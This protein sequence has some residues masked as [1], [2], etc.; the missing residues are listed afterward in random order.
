MLGLKGRVFGHADALAVEQQLGVAQ[1]RALLGVV[2][3]GEDGAVDVHT[4]VFGHGAAVGGGDLVVGVAVGLQHFGDFCQKGCALAIAQGAQRRAALFAGKGKALGQV[5]ARARYAGQFGAQHRVKHRG[6]FACAGLPAA[7]E[8][9]GEHCGGHV[10]VLSRCALRRCG[11][12]E[13]P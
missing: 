9:V 11:G 3:Q 12:V 10:K 1:G 13:M 2:A 5:D 7:C 6:A 4:R 8:K